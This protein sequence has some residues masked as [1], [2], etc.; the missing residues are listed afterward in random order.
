[1]L[2][3]AVRGRQVTVSALVAQLSLLV[4]TPL[5]T[6]TVGPAA[7]GDYQIALAASAFVQ[8][9]LT[10]GLEYLIP[11]S[12][13]TQ[14]ATL[15]RRGR[16]FLGGGLA[17]LALISLAVAMTAAPRVTAI[18]VGAGVVAATYA[19]TILD[20]AYRGSTGDYQTIVRRNLIFGSGIV[21]LQIVA[22]LVWP[23]FWG[24]VVAVL[25]ARLLSLPLARVRLGRVVPGDVDAA[26]P[27]VVAPGLSQNF[28]WLGGVALSSL[29]V[30]APVF[31]VGLHSIDLAGQLALAIRVVGMPAA[32][33][34][35]AVAQ[36][37]SLRIAEMVRTG[38]DAEVGP[39][40]RRAQ[41]R[42]LSVGLTIGV[43]LAATAV[44]STPIVFGPGW[45]T[46]GVYIAILARA[47]RDP[48]GQPH[49]DPDLP[50]VPPQRGPGRLP[51]G[52]ARG[53]CRGHGRAA[54]RGGRRGLVG[55]RSGGGVDGGVRGLR[56]D[57]RPAR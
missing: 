15:R 53:R 7:F 11:A 21:I 32:I 14:R 27:G 46:A 17:A 43:G 16:L 52:P 56:A 35:A 30:Q 36:G 6:R 25:A 54:Q 12:T 44:W 19:F 24:L 5:A 51:P 55:G 28:A 34:G 2:V 9:V 26:A 10:G 18:V 40:I 8:I 3:R 49:R 37:F 23:T 29:A 20:T 50:A 1:M 57:D 39:V 45:S 42:W 47:L 38:R 13:G 48:A 33:L 31:L 22:V 41:R 4:V